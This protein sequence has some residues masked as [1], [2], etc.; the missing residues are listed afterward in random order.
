MGPPQKRNA[1][2]K[3]LFVTVALCTV[4]TR[5]AAAAKEAGAAFST[6]R[7]FAL[8]P[9][10]AT[11]VR[12]VAGTLAIEGADLGLR[13]TLDGRPIDIGNDYLHF[14]AMSHHGNQDLVLVASE[15]AGSACSYLELAFLRLAKGAPPAIETAR[16]FLYPDTDLET[17]A[18]RI[19]YRDQTWSVPLG[20]SDGQER[21][22]TIGPQSKLAIHAVPVPIEPLDADDCRAAQALLEECASFAEPCTQSASPAVAYD[23]PTASMAFQRAITDLADH[24][25]GLNLPRFAAACVAASKSRRPPDPAQV[26]ETICSGADPAQWTVDRAR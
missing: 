14:V 2:A 23:C 13:F 10:D 20:L 7:E 3:L 18:A 16:D 19:T 21:T 22:A 25:T 24:T 11:A 1:L 12:T 8:V 9:D 26:T 15:C 4:C 17:D 5:P 6:A